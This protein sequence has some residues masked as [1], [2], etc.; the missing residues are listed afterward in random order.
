M[1]RAA[2][3][4]KILQIDLGRGWR[5]GQQQALALV[6][7]LADAGHQ[8]LLLARKN[9]PLEEKA[10]NV[11]IPVL[12]VQP[13]LGAWRAALALRRSLWSGFDLIH[14]HD[15]RSHTAAWLAGRSTKI[16]RVVSRRVAYLLPRNFI[17]RQKYRHGAEQYV[18]VSHWVRR[19]LLASGIPE[20]KVHV[21]YDGVELPPET[22]DVLRA[23]ARRLLSLPQDAFVVSCVGHLFRD[24]GQHRLVEAISEL[25]GRRRTFLL[26][27]G[28]GPLAHH[29]ERLVSRWRLEPVVRLLGQLA[30]LSP[31]YQASDLFVFPA[32]NE[33]LGTAML[34]A[35]AHGLPVV[36][37]NLEA[38]PEVIQDGMN[39]LLVA[40]RSPGE[41][42]CGIERLAEDA[43]LRTRLGKE[44]RRTVEARFASA[45]MVRETAALYAELA[46]VR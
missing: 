42:A 21:I 22:D 37:P 28:S 35:M 26:L 31:V 40:N 4:V 9:N 33:G 18:A 15:G 32:M 46:C 38:N 29:L 30:D 20:Q 19:Q 17:S 25:C 36:A 2:N 39:G 13:G 5:G 10:R 7:G 16:P 41:L 11:Q 27:A 43:A 45:I 8:V 34:V 24:K 12:G 3:I 1:D 14:A 6:K 44:A 23:Q